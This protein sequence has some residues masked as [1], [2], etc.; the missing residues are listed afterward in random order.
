MA[1]NTEHANKNEKNIQPD[2]HAPAWNGADP[3]GSLNSILEYVEAEA[4]RAIDWYFRNRVWKSRLSRFIQFF[5]VI[6]AAGAGIVPI[7]AQIWKAIWKPN[8][9]FDSGLLASLLVGIAAG[10]IGLDRAFGYSTGWAR[11]VLTATAIRKALEEFRMDWTLLSAAAARPPT[12]EQVAAM[13]ARAKEFSATVEGLVIQE[14]KDWVT[15]FQSGMAQLEKEVKV[16]L[17][18]LKSQVEKAARDRQT[19]AK[20]GAIELTVANAEKTDGFQFQVVLENESGTVAHEEV[21]HSKTWA[22]IKT[23]PGH[24]KLSVSATAG[25]KPA[26]VSAVVE[27]AP[28]EAAKLALSLPLSEAG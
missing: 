17:D 3:N 4:S 15:E 6:F 18:T 1:A 9:T 19:A 14:T 28:G 5:A 2:P 25:A 16:Q 11:Y 23:A 26:G 13:I 7:L 27:V 21:A 8:S 20:S 22:R 24:Y 10:M 12:S